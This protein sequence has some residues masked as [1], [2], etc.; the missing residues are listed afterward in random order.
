MTSST[1]A[2]H[3]LGSRAGRAALNLL[4]ITALTAPLTLL[5]ACSSDSQTGAA[6]TTGTGGQSTG[7]EGGS[8]QGTGGAPSATASGT[9][10]EGGTGGTDPGPNVDVS[11]P[12]LYSITFKPNDADP[13]AKT[14]LGNQPAY[15]DTRVTPRGLLVVYLHGAGVPGTC[16]STAHEQE[17]AKLGFHVIGPCYESDYG[18]ANCKDDIEGCRLEAFDGTDHHPFVDI[19]PPDSIETRVAKGL[20]YLQAKNPKG[21]WTYY[22]DGDKPRWSR[23]II[24]GISH[25]ASSAGVIGIHRNTS[26]VV[27]LS[28]PLD[29]DQAWLKKTP[30]TPIE[31][32][33]GFTHTADG[34]HAG[35]LA[36]FATM[37]LV[38]KPTSV[39]GATPPYGGT[40][41]LETSAPTSDGHSSLQ[42]GG[43]SPKMG[44][45]YVFKPVWSYL[46]TSDL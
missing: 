17:L 42:A 40:H 16:G 41:R 29:T 19:K 45:E 24:S 13:E 1:T 43:V 9:G 6:S 10:G 38:G 3:L 5:A 27:M 35:H 31:R 33:F 4:A 25:G 7:G 36:A 12:Q 18:V 23:I 34:Q 46:Y 15:L 11:D 20:T 44:T 26:R 21:D 37:G 32:F 2:D 30:L 14:K 28:G 39:D 22:L 8:A